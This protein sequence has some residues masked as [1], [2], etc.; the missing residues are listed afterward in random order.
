MLPVGLL[1]SV[2]QEIAA[3]GNIDKKSGRRPKSILS[4]WIGLSLN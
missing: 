2:P 1:V 3:A 4:L